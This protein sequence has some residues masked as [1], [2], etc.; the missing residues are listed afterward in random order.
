MWLAGAGL[1]F[2][3]LEVQNIEAIDCLALPFDLEAELR[4][5]YLSLFWFV[6]NPKCLSPGYQPFVREH[7]NIC[8][9]GRGQIPRKLIFFFAG[10]KQST[11]NLPL[12]QLMYISYAAATAIDT[13]CKKASA[14]ISM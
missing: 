13:Q 14:N 5:S 3:S 4:V 9:D 1:G 6:H 2:Y 8:L 11:H 7:V 12:Q 10:I